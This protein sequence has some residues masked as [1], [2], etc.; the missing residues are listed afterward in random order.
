MASPGYRVCTLFLS[1]TTDISPRR[2]GARLPAFSSQFLSILHKLENPIFFI[3]VFWKGWLSKLSFLS[4]V[5]LN[6][7]AHTLSAGY[8]SEGEVWLFWSYLY[9]YSSPP[10]GSF[11]HTHI[12]QDGV[13][14]Y[15]GE[16]EKGPS[17]FGWC[18]VAKFQ[19]TFPFKNG[20]N[21]ISTETWKGCLRHC[22]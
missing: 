6:N 8:F 7:R 22:L 16:Q 4:N 1:L 5:P 9:L 11:H 19:R 14:G 13:K 10:E 2:R 18:S 20:Y 17:Y 15:L 12:P 3:W 21:I